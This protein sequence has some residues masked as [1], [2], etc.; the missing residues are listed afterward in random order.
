MDLTFT[1]FRPGDLAEYAGWFDDAET[2]RRLSHPDAAWQAHVMGETGAWAV[3]NAEG[4]L[5]AVVEAEGDGPRGYVSVTVA[6]TRRGHGIGAE[7]LRGF[8]AGPGARFAVLEGRIAPHNAASIS[9]IQRAGFTLASPEPDGDGML[10][11]ELRK[12]Q[13]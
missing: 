2:A 11:F 6:P 9:M 3:R 5:I 8:H 4:D 10:H 1:P 13:K 12:D 7:A